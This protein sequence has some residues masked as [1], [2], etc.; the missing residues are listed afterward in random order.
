[1]SSNL[2]KFLAC[3]MIL[4]VM[5]ACKLKRSGADT[6][7]V[8]DQGYASESG[9]ISGLFDSVPL[10]TSNLGPGSD[11]VM[12]P[13]LR[14]KSWFYLFSRYR[15]ATLNDR[16]KN[17]IQG[18]SA[19][20]LRYVSVYAKKVIP[21]GTQTKKLQLVGADEVFAQSDIARID[22]LGFLTMVID[23]CES[24]DDA[25]EA[26]NLEKYGRSI[27]NSL[28]AMK[29][30]LTISTRSLFTLH[31]VQKF[32]GLLLWD[33]VAN[34]RLSLTKN[35]T[36]NNPNNI[37]VDAAKSL[38]L[39]KTTP[40][41]RQHQQLQSI[42]QSTYSWDELGM[43]T[44][45]GIPLYYNKFAEFS[46]KY[47]LIVGAIPLLGTSLAAADSLLTLQEGKDAQ[48]K[49]VS[50]NKA[51]MEFVLSIALA[52]I[53][54]T[55]VYESVGGPKIAQSIQE[56]TQKTVEKIKNLRSKVQRGEALTAEEVNDF[57]NTANAEA[58]QIA[59]VNKGGGETKPASKIESIAKK[60]KFKACSLST[61]KA[62]GLS[63]TGLAL[64]GD[65]CIMSPVFPELEDLYK[66]LLGADTY[67]RIA[68]NT[69]KY[70]G[71]VNKMV[72]NADLL[73]TERLKQFLRNGEY[74]SPDQY[75]FVRQKVT[76]AKPGQGTGAW[77]SIDGRM[78]IEEL[79]EGD[80][81]VIMA[82][83]RL[84]DSDV[85][86]FLLGGKYVA[87]NDSMTGCTNHCH[88]VQLSES[89][90]IDADTRGFADSVVRDLYDASKHP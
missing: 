60:M 80:V 72:G 27:R 10:L 58:E 26:E 73:Q 53:D 75:F 85:K 79:G 4:I 41:L 47:P 59:G 36:Y 46:S 49:P 19:E 35:E 57:K 39:Q 52:T 38:F 29:D 89:Q 62:L 16:C 7:S 3:W 76:G 43:Y 82:P 28:T 15:N 31:V 20:L 88:E 74:K 11:D 32:P 6:K 68:N 12:D 24:K 64:S 2:L 86:D 13:L 45:S 14:D 77:S 1:M 51:Q 40:S 37:P 78:L 5:P 87:K 83:G 65:D 25:A 56:S 67:N 54:G 81:D 69:Q 71:D 48:G 17:V 23:V 61:V 8:A 90:T 42:Q 55:M 63:T 34:A 66:E 44:N 18:D 30:K 22:L 84:H 50:S 70:V 21:K 33:F 9:S